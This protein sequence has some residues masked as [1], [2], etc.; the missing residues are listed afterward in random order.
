M[1]VHTDGLWTQYQPRHA[2]AWV[3]RGREMPGMFPVDP[4]Q[5]GSSD[6]RR[7]LVEVLREDTVSAQLVEDGGRALVRIDTK[8]ASGAQASYEFPRSDELLARTDAHALAGRKPAAAGPDRVSGRAGR[9][10]QVSQEG[11]ASVLPSGPYAQ[12]LRCRFASS[13]SA[14]SWGT[15][16][17]TKRCPTRCSVWICLRARASA[18]TSGWPIM[19]FPCR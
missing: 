8:S 14:R 17:S 7:P 9:S 3:R 5:V 4:R 11:N 18:T 12:C 2:A 16:G 1:L 6:V 19:W 15:C 13:W 10:S